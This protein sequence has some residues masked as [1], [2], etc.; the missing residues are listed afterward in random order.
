MKE[1]FEVQ[2]S[3]RLKQMIANAVIEEIKDV[4]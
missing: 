2:L 4:K 3:A 1:S